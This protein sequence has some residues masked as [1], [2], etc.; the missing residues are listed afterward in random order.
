[1]LNIAVLIVILIL[2]ILAFKK[3]KYFIVSVYALWEIFY[4]IATRHELTRAFGAVKSEDLLLFIVVIAILFGRNYTEKI[5]LRFFS[6]FI[7]FNMLQIWVGTIQYGQMGIGEPRAYVLL[8]V[9][10]SFT[11]VIYNKSMIALAFRVITM[12]S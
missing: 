3:P 12:H 11:I 5:D 6:I 9:L 2:G 7:L 1:M 10:F 4:I 8:S